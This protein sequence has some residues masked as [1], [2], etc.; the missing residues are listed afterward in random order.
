MGSRYTLDIGLK[1][2]IQ[3][4]K[5]EWILNATDL[6]NTMQIRKTI[7]GTDFSLESTDYYETQVVRVG[8]HQK[9]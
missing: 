4:G 8:Y 7:R 2:S 3:H 9:F 5:G 6:L 1:K